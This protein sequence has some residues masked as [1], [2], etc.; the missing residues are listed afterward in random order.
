MSNHDSSSRL[1]AEPFAVLDQRSRLA[2]PLRFLL[3]LLLA[4]LCP[5]LASRAMGQNIQY[6]DKALDLG[7]RSTVRVDPVTRGI[8]FEIPLGSYAGRAGL[9]MPV[10]LS[11]TS[12]VWDVQFQG[13][14]S[15]PPPPFQGGFQPFTIVTSNYARHSFSGWTSTIGLPSVDFTPS[16][17]VYDMNGFPK[18]SCGMER[19]MLTGISVGIMR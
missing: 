11:Y 5:A 15:G 4:T 16:N 6:D 2:R 12:K 10:T 1:S 9:N 7:M 17:H 19:G 13:Y 3:A 14:A 18:M 8:S